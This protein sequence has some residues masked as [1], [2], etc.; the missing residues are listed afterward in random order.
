MPAKTLD[1]KTHKTITP[2]CLAHTQLLLE[3][4]ELTELWEEYGLVGDVIVCS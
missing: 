4:L 3:V 1:N 2:Q